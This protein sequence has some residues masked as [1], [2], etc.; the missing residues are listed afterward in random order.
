MV[1]F[2]IIFGSWKPW[3][4]AWFELEEDR[5]EIGVTLLKTSFYFYIERRKW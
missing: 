1:S 4:D 3:F 5:L 2:A